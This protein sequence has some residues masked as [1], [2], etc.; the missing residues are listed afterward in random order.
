MRRIYILHFSFLYSIAVFAQMSKP[1]APNVLKPI[2]TITAPLPKWSNPATW[3]NNKVPLQT[4]DVTIP[5]GSVVV[6]DMNIDVRHIMVHGVL[7]VEPSKDITINA[8]SVQIMGSKAYFEWGTEQLPYS[9]KGILTLSK[10]TPNE[11]MPMS[12]NQSKGIM[13]MD[14]GVLEL[15][16][17]I[18]QSSTQLAITALAGTKTL[19][20]K[21]AINWEIGDSIV[22]AST[23][24]MKSTLV[25]DGLLE[26]QNPYLYENETAKIVTISADKKTVTLS[27]ALNYKHWGGAIETFN[28]GKGRSWSLDER[29][30]VGLLSRNIL[31]QGDAASELDRH[32]VN[33]MIMEGSSAKVSGVELFRMGIGSVM[34]RYPFHWH[35]CNDVS[36]QYFNNNSIHHSFNRAVTIHGS[37]NARVE[38]NVIFDVMGHAIF[39]EDG[40]ESGNIID[41]NLI[42]TVNKPKSGLELLDSDLFRNTSDRI[43]GPAAIWMTHPTNTVTNNHISGAGTGIW[44][45]MPAYPSGMSFTKTIN[46]RAEPLGKLDNNTTHSCVVGLSFDFMVQI[47]ENTGVITGI[48]QDGYNPT[49]LQK[50]TRHNSSHDRRGIWFRGNNNNV[51]FDDFVIADGN[52]SASFVPT[53]QTTFRNGCSIGYSKNSNDN[54]LSTSAINMYD[55]P[56]NV[57]DCH[58]VNF[59]GYNQGII[60]INGGANKFLENSVKGLTYLNCNIYNPE[61]A[62]ALSPSPYHS[63]IID[64]DGCLTGKL[65]STICLDHPFYVDDINFKDLVSKSGGKYGWG[66]YT[67]LKFGALILNNQSLEAVAKKSMY[68]EWESPSMSSNGGMYDNL[69]NPF[70]WIPMVVN[71][72]RIYKIRFLDSVRTTSFNYEQS[73]AT[74]DIVRFIIQGSPEM[75]ESTI[76]SVASINLLI[77]TNDKSVTFWD[78]VKKELH[79]KIVSGGGAPKLIRPQFY[80]TSKETIAASEFGLKSRAYNAQNN[81]I[82]TVIEA[83]MF[84]NG[85]PGVAYF[86]DLSTKKIARLTVEARMIP[87]ETRQ[88]QAIESNFRISEIAF[89]HYN[90]S[91]TTGT[92]A[93]IVEITPDEYWN[94]TFNVTADGTFDLDMN[95]AASGTSNK[96]Q[97]F[98]DDVK[99][100]DTT[101]ASLGAA[102]AIRKVTFGNIKLTKGSRV[103]TLKALSGNMTFDNFRIYKRGT[104]ITDIEEDAIVSQNSIF[105]NPSQDGIF[106]L[107]QTTTWEITSVLGKKLMSGNGNQIDLTSY[108]KGIYLVIVGDK[109]ERIIIN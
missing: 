92:V 6:L 70:S 84:D 82:N 31:I 25:E 96:W 58:F 102:N 44:Y 52:S 21:D 62:T 54:N 19:T 56:Q 8:H 94:Y 57:E 49:T 20:F 10:S 99:V 32:G 48:G 7:V 89:I 93:A 39:L 47:D 95:L 35:M 75:L 53:F 107:S 26:S 42:M 34:G 90:L 72:D 86:S 59:D 77:A 68:F 29:A 50:V 76:P 23:N 79:V 88:T 46:P 63:F 108:P 67:D 61:K 55:G 13:V 30:E 97:I 36:G 5:E 16:G 1:Y 37:Q 2:G 24:F 40:I 45:S 106:N 51:E 9:K 4:D 80:T 91:T 14:G 101:F 73:T 22:I 66:K 81:Q 11:T 74:K 105:P 87:K 18:K 98:V 43:A 33:I 69:D 27:D 28:N 3:N 12:G 60:R 38:S 100:K 15:H 85:G 103:I 109:T 71:T 41:S 65:N 104:V 64:R 83:E 78:A 17:K